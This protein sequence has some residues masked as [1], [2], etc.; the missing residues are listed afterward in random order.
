MS[1]WPTPLAGR[2]HAWAVELTAGQHLSGPAAD[3]EID[4]SS[5]AG[6]A[7]AFPGPASR[8]GAR[9]MAAK[10]PRPCW[11][12]PP[13]CG[14]NSSIARTHIG[15]SRSEDGLLND[16]GFGEQEGYLR[17]HIDPR[18]VNDAIAG[19]GAFCSKDQRCA[20]VLR[21]PVAALLFVTYPAQC[22]AEPGLVRRLSSG[23]R[24]FRGSICFS[25]IP[26]IPAVA[27]VAGR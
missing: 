18:K 15:D 7:Y 8:P 20:H 16:L 10:P 6:Q 14:S 22:R 2:G 11:A 25:T 19:Y 3:A 4:P 21:S 9:A 13:P 5:S 24:A 17:G 1:G 26:T 27:R 23:H 12:R